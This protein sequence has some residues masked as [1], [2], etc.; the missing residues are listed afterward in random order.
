MRVKIQNVPVETDFFSEFI[1]D[2]MDNVEAP[3]IQ[4]TEI[5]VP[6]PVGLKHAAEIKEYCE[7]ASEAMYNFLKQYYGY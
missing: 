3:Q 4:K 7:K 1:E 2:A 6:F 5:V